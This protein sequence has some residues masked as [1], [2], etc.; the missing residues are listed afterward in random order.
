MSGRWDLTLY[1]QRSKEGSMK[2]SRKPPSQQAVMN[3]STPPLC[4]C[5]AS[6]HHT[7]TALRPVV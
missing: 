6:E 7:H 4:V 3:I 1:V 2:V 5:H